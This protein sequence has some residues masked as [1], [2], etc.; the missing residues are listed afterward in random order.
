MTPVPALEDL[1]GA[2]ARDGATALHLQIQRNSVAAMA[3]Q[4]HALA[5][6]GNFRASGSWFNQAAAHPRATRMADRI[7]IRIEPHFISH[8]MLAR[9]G[10]PGGMRDALAPVLGLP[11]GVV[12]AVSPSGDDRLR[13]AEAIAGGADYA[14]V[15]AGQRE[16]LQAAAGMDCDAILLDGLADRDTAVLAFDLARAGQRIVIAIDAISA[17][18]A[19]GVLRALRVERHLVGAGLRAVVAVHGVQRLCPGCRLPAQARASESALLGIDPG[20]VIYRPAG[21]GVCDGTGYV[22]TALVF[23]AIAVDGALHGLLAKGADAALLAR[24]AFIAAP[25]LAA[26]ARIL[27]R[28][29]RITPEEA[30]RI[31][32]TT[33]AAVGAGAPHP[34]ILPSAGDLLDDRGLASLSARLHGDRSSIG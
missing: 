15:V 25:T 3:R 16:A 22:G 30:I 2:A 24:Y 7:V 34:H 1:I 17:I 8:D 6:L 18:A 9:L 11:G 31:T 5:P 14:P 4:G 23:E 19:I 13:L 33:A 10:M 20:T 28:E 32:R 21:C 12:L 26:S 27:A 29:G